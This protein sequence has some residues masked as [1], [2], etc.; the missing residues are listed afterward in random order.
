MKTQA[1]IGPMN[2]GYAR[3]HLGEEEDVDLDVLL[4][5]L[6]KYLPKPPE[7]GEIIEITLNEDN[8]VTDARPL[9]EVTAKR[10]RESL[11]IHNELLYGISKVDEDV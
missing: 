1:F 5:V 6:S 4:S 11:A 2:S 8:E 10:H 3:L 9:P 7:E